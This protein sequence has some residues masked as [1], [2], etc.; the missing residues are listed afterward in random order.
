M[1]PG[2]PVSMPSMMSMEAPD[3]APADVKMQH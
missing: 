1:A 2:K 3:T